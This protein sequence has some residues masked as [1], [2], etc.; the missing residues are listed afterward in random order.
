MK[1]TIKKN[2]LSTLTLIV[3]ATIMVSY[4]NAGHNEDKIGSLTSA[5]TS[6]E[7]DLSLF[8]DTANK[9]SFNTYM[10]NFSTT[11]QN[12]QRTMD[13]IVRG[14]DD[15]FSKEVDALLEYALQQFNILVDVFKRYNGKP[16]SQAFNFATE[17]KREFDIEKIFAEMIA[18][19]KNLR[20]KAHQAGNKPLV[21]LIEDLAAKIQ[22]K[23][24]VWGAKQNITLI[25][26]LIH[27]MK[28]Q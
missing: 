11:L 12:L 4:T 13:T 3:L 22:Q 15:E 21:K 19:L 2:R 8:V 17:I 5:F 18:K 25:G 10:I 14:Q 26:G 24:K 6:V 28:C 27:R 9:T 7:N 16:E 1:Y 20:C 23:K